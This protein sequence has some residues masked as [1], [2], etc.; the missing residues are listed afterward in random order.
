MKRQRRFVLIGGDIRQVYLGRMLAEKGESVTAVGLERH[1][2]GDWFPL[3]AD[4]RQACREAAI[5]VLPLPVTRERG[6]LNAP[7]ANAP[8]RIADVLDA[9]PPGALVFGGSVPPMVHEMAA[10]RALL[11]HD[12]LAQE[13]L[14]V[15]NAI[16]TAEGAIQIAMEHLPV[17]IHALPVLI[18]G[19]G[20]IGTALA[21]RLHA[22][23]AN[24]TVSARRYEDFARV[25][26]MGWHTA[27]TRAL[28]GTLAS[29]ALIV[30][31]VPA[32]V[33]TRPLAAECREDVLLLDLASGEGG[34]APNARDLRP[35]IHA[36]S[37]P[38]RVAPVTAAAD[39]CETITHMLEEEGK[40]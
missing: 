21:Q 20:R 17:T 22:L 38:G 18:I 39:I 23:G 3:T 40:R 10:R 30:N 13:E 35:C 31:T 7:L 8:F 36:L 27:D 15:R 9:I 28:S 33:L 37:L 11:I 5:L 24:V 1:E 14:A 2:T 6:L 12:Y 25:S 34:I 29:Y 32:E 16:P 19:S 26:A 4:W